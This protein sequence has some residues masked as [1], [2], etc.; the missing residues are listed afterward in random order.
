[1]KE[2]ARASFRSILVAFNAG[3][4]PSLF[5]LRRRFHRVRDVQ[6]RGRS[7][8]PAHEPTAGGR[9]AIATQH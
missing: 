5:E 2:G 9:G 7:E 1:M 6:P 4:A 3:G 8:D